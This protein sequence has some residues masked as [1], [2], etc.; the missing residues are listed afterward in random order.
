MSDLA[1]ARPESDRL[2]FIAQ[3]DGP[4][5]ARDWAERTLGIYREAM[6]TPGSH[7][8]DAVFRPLFQKSVGEFEEWLA[9]K[10]K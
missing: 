2:A 3:R 9:A 10:P 6:N 5:A 7:A 8:A 4:A 1:N